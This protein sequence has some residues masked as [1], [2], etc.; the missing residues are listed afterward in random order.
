[1]LTNWRLRDGGGT[2][3]S[4]GTIASHYVFP[5]DAPPEVSNIS[6]DDQDASR[7]RGD[8]VLFGQDYRDGTTVTFDIQVDGGDSEAEANRLLQVLAKA[9]RGDYARATP[10]RMM[11]LTSHT[12]REAFGR[13]RRFQPK[14]D[15][16]PFGLTAVT[17][18]F[19]TADDL[20][21]DPEDMTTIK[22]IPDVGGGLIAPL[23]S[24]LSTTAS[25]DRSQ[26]VTVGGTLPTWP[27]ITLTGP[28]T[29]P[30]IEVVGRFRLAFNISLAADQSL[31]ID[32]RPWARSIR[33]NGA[34]VA[35][36]L[37]ASGNRLSD[38][39]MPPGTYN[40]AF[41]G[42][43]ATGTPQAKFTWRNAYPTF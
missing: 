23:A 34:N 43:S 20:W 17:C 26:V 29:N 40:I 25:S 1:M 9:W 21:Y 38:A 12:G 37:R 36:T 15:L 5:Q 11:V 3:I 28:I 2:D 41:R 4:F 35:G 22:L 14:Y 32:T 27:V 19:Q 18:D 31:V 13:P 39:S 24:P 42:E 33:R 6:I 10:G 16:T 7:P 30:E 8:G